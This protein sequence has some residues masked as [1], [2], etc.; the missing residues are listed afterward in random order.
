MVPLSEMGSSTRIINIPGV[1]K[2]SCLKNFNL[3]YLLKQLVMWNYKPNGEIHNWDKIL[4][5]SV[6][7]TLE[8]I[9]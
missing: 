5:L 8:N 2:Q 7:L 1:K 9:S 3:R 4:A 6:K